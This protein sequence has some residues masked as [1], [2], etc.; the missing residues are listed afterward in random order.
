MR[1][2]LVEFIGTFFLM[3]TIILT[4]SEEKGFAIL[5]VG[6]V[7]IALIYAGI[8]ISGAHFN[9]AVTMAVWMRGKCRA[10]DIPGYIIA[11]ILGAISATQ[12]G[13]YLLAEMSAVEGISSLNRFTPFR[14][15]I[16]EYLGTFILVFVIL[17]V[18][19]VRSSKGNSFYGLAI[20]FT[21]IGCAYSMGSVTGGAF[22]PAVVLGMSMAGLIEWTNLWIY[23]LG[24]FVAAALA[25]WTFLF[26]N[27]EA[28]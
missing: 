10:I 28:A 12:I 17:N 16:A 1:K 15:M 25:T 27:N 22:N 7:L 18:A 19:T 14:G 24:Q 6:C 26:V 3:L 21:V 13:K 9:P 11:Q 20:G 5:S 23:C 8:H 2:Y 4:V